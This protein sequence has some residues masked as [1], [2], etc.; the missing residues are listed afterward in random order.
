MPT[1][2]ELATV[3]SVTL[4]GGNLVATST[5]TT[6]ANQGAHAPSTDGQ[7]TGKYYFEILIGTVAAGVNRSMGI[8]TTAS[9]YTNM[10]SS[11]TTGVVMYYTGAIWANGGNSGSSLGIRSAGQYIGI[12]A[13]LD[14][15]RA[16][17]RV[18]PSGNWNNSGTADPATNVGGITVPAGTMVPF[19]TFGGTGGT[20]GNVLTANFG[21]SA[22]NG[23]VPSGFVAG[24]PTPGASASAQARVVVM[25]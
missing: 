1:T 3:A 14:N 6:S 21:A 19:I 23:P 22:F 4:S 24:F 25:A 15:R 9:T 17:F 11:A 12:A 16:W 5:G 13:D 2:W 8:G 7:T 10:G 18:T 20:A